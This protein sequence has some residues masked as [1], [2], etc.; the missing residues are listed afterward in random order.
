MSDPVEHLQDEIERLTAENKRLQDV[1]EAARWFSIHMPAHHI[2]GL[3]ER[4]N[5]QALCEAVD[6][7]HKDS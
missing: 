1:Y 3:I 7:V 4:R 5:Y 6:A 2:P